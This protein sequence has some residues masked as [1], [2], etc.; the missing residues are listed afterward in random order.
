MRSEIDVSAWHW[1]PLFQSSHFSYHLLFGDRFFSLQL[2][3]SRS[4]STHRSWSGPHANTHTHAD[5]LCVQS[6]HVTVQFVKLI[7]LITN[8]TLATIALDESSATTHYI[9]YVTTHICCCWLLFMY[10]TFL[11][12]LFLVIVVRLFFIESKRQSCRIQLI[13][14]NC[15]SE[16]PCDKLPGII[17]TQEARTHTSTCECVWVRVSVD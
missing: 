8:A 2:S 4:R 5:W 11:L 16:S 3:M 10:S 1:I 14:D 9:V 6:S 7:G 15:L 17:S 12:L 13:Y